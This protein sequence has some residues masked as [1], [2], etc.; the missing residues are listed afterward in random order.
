MKNYL[1]ENNTKII[2]VLESKYDT[3]ISSELA[4]QLDEL[5]EYMSQLDLLNID[6]KLIA[7]NTIIKE[8]IG[9]V[10]KKYYIR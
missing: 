6:Y 8:N 5:V 7:N 1:S 10:E 9:Y 2:G 3:D 4:S